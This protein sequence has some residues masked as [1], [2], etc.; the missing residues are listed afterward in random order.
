MS[1]EFAKDVHGYD[2]FMNQFSRAVTLGV[3]LIIFGFSCV[4][5]LN[6]IGIEENLSNVVFFIFL[7]ISVMIFI[8]MGM[9]DAR[10]REKH[11]QIEDF[12]KEE[13]KE[14]AYRKFTVRIALGVG[15]ILIGM[16]LILV[17]DSRLASVTVEAGRIVNVDEFA[18]G[19]FLLMVA[20]AVSI[21]VYGGMQKEKYNIAGYNKEGNPSPEK[22]RR[23][24]L[25]WKISACIML[26]ATGSFL[27][28]GFVTGKWQWSWLFFAVGGL[29]CAIVKV[30]ISK[31]G[32]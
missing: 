19:I 20:V 10:F 25:I 30:M 16:L 13:E 5:M 29:L 32:E 15:I 11:P 21:L 23:D 2:K 28:F 7:I 27:V 4:C 24:A 17:T 1:R 18:N 9:Q 14:Q 8:V 12:Y 3:G 31:D 22:K 6:G 26:A